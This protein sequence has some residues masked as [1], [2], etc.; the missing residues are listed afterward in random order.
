MISVQLAKDT[1][2]F[3]LHVKDGQ[4]FPPQIL[5]EFFISALSRKLI[6]DYLHFPEGLWSHSS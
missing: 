4:N 6:S 3:P 5:G 1:F 2:V